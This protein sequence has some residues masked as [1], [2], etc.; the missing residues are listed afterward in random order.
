MQN[1]NPSRN[2]ARRGRYYLFMGSV[3]FFG[4][5]IAVTLGALFFFFPL[6]ETTPFGILR[7]LLIIA[8]VIIAIAGVAS[9]IRGLTLQKDNPLA[10]AVGE[11]LTQFLDNR[12]TYLRNVS[13]HKVGYID[14]VLI[15]PPGALVFRIVDYPG[16]WINERAEWINRGRNGGL[17]PAR[18][19]PTRE[20]VRDVVALRK[21]FAKRGLEK[22]PI[23]AVV[24]FT[25]PNANLSASGPA[26]P[27]CEIPTL[28][29]IMR[30]DYLAD[31][32]IAPPTVRAA[33][34]AIIDG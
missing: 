2:I 25:S 5:A 14:A 26:V 30:R 23:Y 9:V 34:D 13:K 7:A 19:N 29:Q 12:Y 11:A 32:R 27:I 4:G 10:Y 6:W 18:T 3:A 16:V 17:R 20:C 22:V 31:E 1:I 21:F 8:G 33:V 28:Y 15:G 24:V